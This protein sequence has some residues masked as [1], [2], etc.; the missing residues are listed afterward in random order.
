M[1]TPLQSFLWRSLAHIRK[2]TAAMTDARIKATQEV[3]QG[4][5]VIKFFSWEIPYIKKIG[6]IR[7]KE[8]SYVKRKGFIQAFVTTIAFS[9]PIICASLAFVIYSLTSP[10]DPGTVFA[11]LT[12]FYLLRFPLMFLPAVISGFADYKVAINRYQDFFLAEELDSLQK[13]ESKE[14]EF[15]VQI[16]N[17]EFIWDFNDQESKKES[18]SKNTEKQTEKQNE[19]FK[20]SDVS[21]SIPKGSLVAVIGAVGS[22]KSSLLNGIL[23]EMKRVSG[24]VDVSGSIGYCPQQAWIQNGTLKDNILFGRPFDKDRY[25]KVIRDC[26]LEPDLHLLPDGD[27]TQIGERGINL[28]GNLYNLNQ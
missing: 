23:G 12:W 13:S 14:N 20:L 3:L 26:A 19:F 10:L 18:T 5:R 4:I 8:I 17:A 24:Q 7:L 21:L 22:G 11:S 2:E 28:S 27:N 15:A 6:D 16:D 1:L 9:I 25:Y